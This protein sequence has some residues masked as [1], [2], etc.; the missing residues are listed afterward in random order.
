MADVTLTREQVE[1]PIS[2]SDLES[3]L[4]SAQQMKDR[5]AIYLYSLAL[6]S[7]EPNPARELIEKMVKSLRPFSSI[8]QEYAQTEF[9]HPT[10]L[11]VHYLDASNALT[12]AEA[13]LANHKGE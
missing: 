3:F 10:V 5:R 9:L 4:K 8:W 13:W 12:E 11:P 7:F 1:A 2:K 6:K